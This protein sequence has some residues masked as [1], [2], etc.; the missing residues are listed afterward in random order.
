MDIPA[1]P[2]EREILAAFKM[3][4]L[5]TITGRSSTITNSFVQA[6]IPVVQP[7]VTQ[8]VEVLSLLGMTPSSVECVYCGD[9]STE[10]DHLNSLVS[11]KRPTGF[12]STIR[13]LVPSCGKCNQSRGG[14]H[15]KAWMTGSAHWSPSTRKI[16]DLAQRIERLERFEKWADCRSYDFE[17]LIGVELWEEYR[18]AAEEVAGSL[19]HAQSVAERVKVK[20]AEA[21]ESS[22]AI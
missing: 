13:N 3:P 6:I 8:I 2:S 15:W 18:L 22:G 11:R 21:L 4:R 20:L 14:S 16:P 19:A 7:S 1:S 10:W 12:W 9:A 17:S 5:V